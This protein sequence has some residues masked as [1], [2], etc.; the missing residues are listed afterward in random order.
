MCWLVPVEKPAA[1]T[2]ILEDNAATTRAAELWARRQEMKGES[3]TWMWWTE[4]SR[5]DEGRVG[6]AVLYLIAEGWTAFSSYLGM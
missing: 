6:A 2:M 5:T 1:K 3:G 4:R